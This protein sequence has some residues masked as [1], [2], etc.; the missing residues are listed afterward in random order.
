MVSEGDLHVIEDMLADILYR[1][2]VGSLIYLLT[3][4]RPVL[5]YKV[6]H[7][8]KFVEKP[9]MNHRK[10]VKLIL[11]Y[12]NG[13]RKFGLTYDSPTSLDLYGFVDSY[14]TGD[15]NSL[16]SKSGYIFMMCRG[17]VS[18]SSC[19]QDVVALSSAMVEN[20]SFCSGTK[21]SICLRRLWCGTGKGLKIETDNAIKLR[22]EPTTVYVDNQGCINLARNGVIN[23][24]IKI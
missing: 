10:A 22:V 21:E 7:L 12:L 9:G 16:M 13:S 24:R 2:A 6:A 15:T 19:Q 4:I 18:W 20:V 17:T 1:R 5:S 23:K 8:A 3:E 14:G 11:Q